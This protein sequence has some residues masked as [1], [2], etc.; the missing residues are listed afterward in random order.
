MRVQRMDWGH[1]EWMGPENPIRG[2]APSLHMGKVYIDAGKAMPPHVHYEEQF[3][4]VLE[5]YGTGYID[6]KAQ[7]FEPGA[8]FY[9]PAGC[10]HEFANE[11]QGP[12]VHLM[13][14]SPV[15]I[16][17]DSLI[18][19]SRPVS[20]ER[21]SLLY[22]AIEAIRP[23][24]LDNNMRISFA[25]RDAEGKVLQKSG[26]F[27]SFCQRT[28]GI[29]KNHACVCL[30]QGIHT[31]EASEYTFVCP[32]GW[33]IFQVPILCEEQVLGVIQGGYIRQSHG[34]FV[35]KE[36]GLPEGET[37]AHE[38]YDMPDSNALGLLQL[39]RKAAR[40][41]RNFCEFEQSRQELLEKEEGL[42]NSLDTQ[43]ALENHL[44]SVEHAI[45]NL[46]INN[47]FL[48]NTL[49][50]M[51]SMALE[52]GVFPL[53]QSIIDLS[54][55]LRYSV[56]IQALQLPLRMEIEY[57]EAYLKLQ[58]LRY[59]DDLDFKIQME[60]AAGEAAVPFNFLQPIVEN[61]F[62]HGFSGRRK[63]RLE[64][65]VTY[66]QIQEGEPSGR[67]CI[68][69]WNSGARISEE[70]CRQIQMRMRAGMSHGLAM[71]Y[72]KLRAAYGE[73]FEI[74]IL[75]GKKEGMRFA[76]WIP[77]LFVSEGAGEQGRGGNYD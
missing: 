63:K 48:F 26:Y 60:E 41:L 29:L 74:E 54:K 17:T 21:Q 49:N 9:M 13:V 31:G 47:H 28:C 2:E 24:F 70:G 56:R 65:Q 7:K 71:V 6:G 73:E 69:V 25:I 33:T 18:D 39:L 34:Q 43:R 61:A 59:P 1:I 23:Q 4:Y 66:R 68:S 75:P 32:Y 35:K 37:E 67:I 16:E 51:A 11:G 50:S 15:S 52:S 38:G 64:I 72:E 3:L 44:R 76:V 46:K 53:Y 62:T 20:Q 36:E 12:V 27:P 42:S 40:A 45:T 55:M 30:K 10:T 19:K 58:R 22:A 77:F 8:V 14:S 57:L 5:G